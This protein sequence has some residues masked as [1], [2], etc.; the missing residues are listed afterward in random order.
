MIRR[1]AGGF[2]RDPA[3][4]KLGKIEFV[5]KDIDDPNRIVLTDPVFQQ[6]RKQRAL[7]AI[8]SLNEAL[9]PILR[10]KP[11]EIAAVKIT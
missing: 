3:K 9:H 7:A 10:S 4:S 6:F 1:P 11:E 2:R 8:R 5:D